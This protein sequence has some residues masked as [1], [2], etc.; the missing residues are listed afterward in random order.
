MP[1]A[2]VSW[3]DAALYCNARSKSDGKDTVYLY[4]SRT[5]DI[6][7]QCSLEEC[8]I[9][10]T[11]DGY[12][13]PTEAEWEYACKSDSL[14]LYFW[15]NDRATASLY[16][17]TKEN[18]AATVHQVADKLPN[19]SQ[20]YDMSGNVWE[21]CQDWYDAGFYK[22]SERVDPQGPE[23]GTTKVIRGGSWNTTLFFAQAGTRVSMAPESGDPTIGFRTV[24]TIR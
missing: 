24:L 14:T 18:S 9:S 23:T 17:W 21:W 16:A 6:G 8:T 22:V 3:Y 19:G 4:T 11:A 2:N 20:L 1:V 10:A 12:R 15:G 5:G 13:L 7:R